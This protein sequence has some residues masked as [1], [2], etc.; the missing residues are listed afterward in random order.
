MKA[1]TE[2]YHTSTPTM[3]SSYALYNRISQVFPPADPTGIISTH[4]SSYVGRA[5]SSGHFPVEMSEHVVIVATSVCSE[6][7]ATGSMAMARK[8]LQYVIFQ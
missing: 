7:N 5:H 3:S 6:E 8:K 1:L 2:R 4:T